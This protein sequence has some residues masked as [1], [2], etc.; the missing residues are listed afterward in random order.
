MTMLVQNQKTL[1]AVSYDTTTFGL[2]SR[3]VARDNPQ[4]ILERIEPDELF[5]NPDHSRQYINL[6]IRD[7]DE[8]K[9]VSNFLDTNNLDRF[10][11]ID[12][13][14]WSHPWL[15]HQPGCVIFGLTGSHKLILGK[16]VII[17][18]QCG[19]GENVNVGDGCFF[20]GGCCLA[21]S[22]TIGRFCFV[23]LNVTILDKIVI[24]DDVHLLPSMTIKKNITEPGK[25]YNPYVFKTKKLEIQRLK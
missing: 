8:R 24:G 20:S 19:F 17:Q 18:G 25:Y 16:D 10:S 14:S 6:V 13:E 5:Q 7:F 15:E 11:Y 4:C 1:C 9:K 2:L 3:C 21:D 22:V 23:S 12:H